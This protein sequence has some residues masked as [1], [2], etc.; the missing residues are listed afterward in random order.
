MAVGNA[1]RLIDHASALLEQSISTDQ[2]NAKAR[3]ADGPRGVVTAF[4]SRK[5]VSMGP[6]GKPIPLSWLPFT[7]KASST[8]PTRVS[9]GVLRDAKTQ[10]DKLMS[11]AHEIVR[12]GNLVPDDDQE[13]QKLKPAQSHQLTEL[14][15]WRSEFLHVCENESE[16]EEVRCLKSILLSYWG[17]CYIFLSA[18]TSSKQTSF[19]T[20]LDGFS[21]IIDNAQVVL[22]RVASGAHGRHLFTFDPTIIIPPLYF[23][24]TKCREPI[25]RRKALQL[26]RQAPRR[27][28]LWSLM[29][30]PGVVEKIVAIEEDTGHFVECPSLS[31]APKLPQERQRIQHVAIVST[32]MTDG[33]RRLKVRFTKINLD[34]DRSTKMVDEDVWVEDCQFNWTESPEQAMLV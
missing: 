8:L 18:C 17:M 19:D 32:E 28:D 30:A 15:T 6:L 11:N 12:I 27:N 7:D 25:L 22:Q 31:Q 34:V 26:L 29:A 3:R 21:D 10:L 5:A 9:L 20:H 24:A 2:T 14:K 4:L 23:V 33:R 16:E 13:M 1:W